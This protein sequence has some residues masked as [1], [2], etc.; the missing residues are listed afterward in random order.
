MNDYGIHCAGT[1]GSGKYGV[2]K[3]VNLITVKV[4]NSNESGTMSNIIGGVLW[5]AEQ[6]ATKLSAAE[7]E[8]A[9]TGQT[10]YKGF[11]Y[12]HVSG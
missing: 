1:I 4:L 12:Q 7:A 2:A 3:A 8:Y 9:T 6:A 10:K 5:A 11:R